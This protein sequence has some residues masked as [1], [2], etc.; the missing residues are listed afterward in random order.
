MRQ[1]TEHCLGTPVRYSIGKWHGIPQAYNHWN[2]IPWDIP[3]DFPCSWEFPCSMGTCDTRYQ[4]CI[5][6][7]I[8]YWIPW[9][10]NVTNHGDVQ[11]ETDLVFPSTF[12]MGPRRNSKYYASH[13]LA[14][15]HVCFAR[16]TNIRTASCTNVYLFAIWTKWVW[17][18]TP[19]LIILPPRRPF[20]IK[21][22]LFLSASSWSHPWH[23]THGEINLGQWTVPAHVG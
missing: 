18:A 13:S 22:C 16:K 9:H 19:S 6:N 2:I 14:L 21:I 8:S 4:V 1:P 15:A 3:S 10:S 23:R 20:S 17:V 5:N 11:W 7:W 12:F